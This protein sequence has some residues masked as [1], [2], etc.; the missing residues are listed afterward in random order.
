MIFEIGF[1]DK[2]HSVRDVLTSEPPKTHVYSGFIIG[3]I[4]KTLTD[5]NKRKTHPTKVGFVFI[6]LYHTQQ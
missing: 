4:E 2:D 1:N 3:P 6:E 5:K